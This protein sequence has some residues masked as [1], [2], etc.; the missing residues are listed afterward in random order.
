MRTYP[1][2]AAFALLVAGLNLHAQGWGDS[3]ADGQ[4]S[5]YR[6]LTLALAEPETGGGGGAPGES[7]PSMTELNKELVN[8]VSTLW[9]MTFLQN[10]YWLDT[11]PGK[12]NE[13]A[14]NLLFQPVLPLSL[15]EDWNLIN[16][17][18]FTLVN[19][20]PYANSQGTV[21]RTTGFGDTTLVEL[22]SPGP[23]LVGPWLLG[24]GPSAIFPTAANT[25][26]GQGKWQIGPA[27]VLGYLG[28]KFAV[29]VFPQQWWSYAGG[30]AQSVS[31]M[32]LQYFLVYF[33][34]KG[35]SIEMAPNILV[36][37]KAPSGQQ[38]TFPVGLGLGKVVKLGRLPV[39]LAIEAQYMPVHPDNYGQQW[40]I[41]FKI[42][43]VIP[44]LI[45]GTLFGD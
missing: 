21:S 39:K 3:H 31:Q 15:T 17:P 13:M 32:N 4:P 27:A 14:H 43:P 33:P 34:A 12:P 37:W 25:H 19:S 11:P 20:V 23:S 28:D 45:K 29:G 1:I 8:P 7:G 6:P 22:V 10:N 42:S 9:S 16:H 5:F 41:Q 26:L 2:T 35:W 30:G 18:V 36:D 44:K 24:L 40:N 38:L